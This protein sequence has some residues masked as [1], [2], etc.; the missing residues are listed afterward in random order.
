MMRANKFGAALLALALLGGAAACSSSDGDS[1][2][3]TDKESSTTTEEATSSEDASGGAGASSGDASSEDP[4]SDGE[5]NL[6]D[7]LGG[8]FGNCMEVGAQYA[9][10]LMAVLGG[11]EAMQQ[12]MDD[13]DAI[14]G[15]VPEDI[16]DD[17]DVIASGLADTNG[18][19]EAGEFM[20]SDEYK[21][22]D[23]NITAYLEETCGS[24]G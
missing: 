3:K 9:S 12:A 22:A 24:A 1:A 17:L 14:K 19:I 6:D 7:V 10:V 4:A 15:E 11:D 8:D 13:L 2:E 23:K 20:D 18:I 16:Q 5:M 21:E